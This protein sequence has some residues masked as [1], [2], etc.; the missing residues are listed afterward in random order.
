MACSWSIQGPGGRTTFKTMPMLL[1]LVVL[2]SRSASARV[3][4]D[5][6]EDEQ[7]SHLRLLL[8]NSES[9]ARQADDCLRLS[10]YPNSSNVRSRAGITDRDGMSAISI[11][12]MVR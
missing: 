5:S 9:D 1:V 10:C 8:T 4:S 11:S 7:Q 2:S 3:L 6:S 12:K